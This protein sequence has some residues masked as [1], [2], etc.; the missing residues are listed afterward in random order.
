M[1]RVLENDVWKWAA[2]P[3]SAFRSAWY[4]FGDPQLQKQVTYVTIWVLTLGNPSLTMRHYKDFSLKPI[5]ER[6]YLSQPPDAQAQPVLG[7]AVL[8]AAGNLYREPRLVPL[9]YSVAHQ[10]AAWFCF[11]IET[12]EDLVLVG[13]EYEY[14]DKGQRVVPGV[15]K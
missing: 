10:S 8:G 12:S 4:D 14:S 7:S 3:V 1:G 15:Q 11:E 13:F 9:R 6:T 5:F 2:P